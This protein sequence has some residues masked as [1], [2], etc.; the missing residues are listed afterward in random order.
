MQHQQN[1]YE[2]NKRLHLRVGLVISTGQI[3]GQNVA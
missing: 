1:L 3:S 2:A